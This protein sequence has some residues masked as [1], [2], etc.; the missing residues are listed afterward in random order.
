M[1]NPEYN[2]SLGVPPAPLGEVPQSATQSTVIEHGSHTSRNK[3]L[4]GAL[5]GALGIGG[6]AYKVFDGEAEAKAQT[7]PG[8][9]V[10]VDAMKSD[11]CIKL[12]KSNDALLPNT[13]RGQFGPNLEDYPY[14]TEGVT[15]AFKYFNEHLCRDNEFAAATIEYSQHGEDVKA[16][17]VDTRAD[18]Y[19]GNPVVMSEDINT[20]L[21]KVKNVE[22][23]EIKQRYETLSMQVG[24]NGN[25][26]SAKFDSPKLVGQALVLTVNNED[27]TTKELMFRI[28]CNEQPVSLKGFEFVPVT[29]APSETTP[30]SIPTVGP[31][32]EPTPGSTGCIVEAKPNDGEYEYDSVN[33]TWRKVTDPTAR[34]M[35]GG[36]PNYQ[37]PQTPRGNQGVATQQ[38]VTVPTQAPAPRPTVPLTP[39]T[40]P[41]PPTDG[42]YNGGA[43]TPTPNAVATPLPTPTEVLPSPGW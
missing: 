29:P 23:R 39:N 2:T 20:L 3:W 8:I 15:A 35:T 13:P 10:N 42:G 14:T 6:L 22:L 12:P 43:S 1:S 27:G 25:I 30:V 34:V 11:E 5:V 31:S 40:P 37:D 41:P 21:G 7:S 4:A 9:G 32:L 17:D 36:Q 26:R 16:A 38:P 19:Q 28:V 18:A 33:C 24:D